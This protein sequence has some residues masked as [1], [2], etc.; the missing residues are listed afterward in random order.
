[1]DGSK[2][3]GNSRGVFLRKVWRIYIIGN[4]PS[5]AVDPE[6][7]SYPSRCRQQTRFR[8]IQLDLL[9]RS[10]GARQLLSEVMPSG[11]GL[12]QGGAGCGCIACVQACL[13]GG[14]GREGRRIQCRPQNQILS[15]SGAHIHNRGLVE[16][17]R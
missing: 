7:Q 3:L 6:G 4:D 10:R 15:V 16:G 1:M 17:A 12:R 14:A 9:R 5:L 2:D 13:C 11:V 8:Q